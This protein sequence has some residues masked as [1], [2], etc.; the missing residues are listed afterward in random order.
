MER[1]FKGRLALIKLG[2][3]ALQLLEVVNL[4][5]QLALATLQLLQDLLQLAFL[6]GEQVVDIAGHQATT[7]FEVL[8]FRGIGLIV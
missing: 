8:G 2:D 6:L 3:V 4:A 5:V 1:W 7:G